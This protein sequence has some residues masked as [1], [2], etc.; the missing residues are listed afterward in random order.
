MFTEDQVSY[1]VFHVPSPT[2]LMKLLVNTVVYTI[3][4]TVL[5]GT[6][7]ALISNVECADLC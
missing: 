2:V 4:K 5:A 3:N 7:F 6:L 1:H